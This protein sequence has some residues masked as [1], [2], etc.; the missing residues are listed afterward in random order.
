MK[1]NILF[2]ILPII[3]IVIFTGCVTTKQNI[4]VQNANRIFPDADPEFPSDQYCFLRV[5]NMVNLQ[6]INNNNYH[7]VNGSGY[8]F[9]PPG[10]HLLNVRF[11]GGVGSNVNFTYLFERGKSYL[12]DYTTY[13]ENPKDT[14][15]YVKFFVNEVN[16]PI[17][18]IEFEKRRNL[19][20]EQKKYLVFSKTNPKYLDGTWVT[21][22]SIPPMDTQITFSGNKFVM[23][24]YNRLGKIRIDAEGVYLYDENTIILFYKE[25]EGMVFSIKEAIYYEFKNKELYLDRKMLMGPK[26]NA[27]GTGGNF[28][29]ENK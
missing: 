21:T 27:L 28:T 18:D 14:K 11:T 3:L 25:I 13:R 16:D 5:Q 19:L 12:L 29:K 2:F 9:V 8:I 4:P 22:S 1:K 15:F 7:S 23:N 6:A 20:E 17:A 24:A 10:N 26:G